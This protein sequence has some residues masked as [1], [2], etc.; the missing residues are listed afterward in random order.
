MISTIW[1]GI[2]IGSAKT[3]NR[4]F[5]SATHEGMADDRGRPGDE[6]T[7]L[8]LRLAAGGVGGIFTG[9]CC[10]SQEGR[11]PHRGVLMLDSADQIPSFKKMTAALKKT[12]VPLFLQLVHCGRAT[13]RE[14]TGLPLVAP[15]PIRDGMF[16][17]EKP[18]EL[19][20][21]GIQRIIS[22]FIQAG[23]RASHCGFDGIQLHLAHG[24]LLSQFLSAYSNRRKDRWGGSIENRFRI[25]KEI[26]T[27]LKHE[28]PDFP[29]TVKMNA[30]DQRRRGM[31]IDQAVQIATLL[32][33]SGCDGIEVSCGFPEDG[34]LSARGPKI[35]F[36]AVF[37]YHH[38][39]R[40]LP[41]YAKK[42]VKLLSPVLFGKSV[43]LRNYNV[44]A[45]V[46]I[47]KYIS[48]PVFAVGGIHRLEDIVEAVV[49][50]GL[51]G[52]SI[53]RPLILEPGLIKKF[54]EGKTEEA[55][56]SMC[57][58]CGVIM[59]ENKLRCYYGKLP[60]N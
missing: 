10:V 15:S 14:A 5:R 44:E 22:D 41:G 3:A 29:V 12:G 51:D 36:D 9:Y 7:K 46:A 19:T 55:R 33:Q 25:I 48:L 37:K 52:V 53:S 45:A 49:N 4:I 39:Y 2:A 11:S 40:H 21:E 47:K 57:N 26:I 24:F 34:D 31:R 50:K 38:R 58:Y 30:Y 59:E 18:L 32:E 35:P 1:E 54:R 13:T 43:E 27:G 28:L 20:E 8:Y 42:M 17:G 56:C 16:P 23:I 6:L 60:V